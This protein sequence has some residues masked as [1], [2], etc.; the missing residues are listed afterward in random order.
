[1]DKKDS[2]QIDID[3]MSCAAC[4]LRIEKKL[5]GLEG[6]ESVNVNL[7]SEKAY[8][9]YDKSKLSADTIINAVESL[10]YHAETIDK[11]LPG[12]ADP[13]GKRHSD[14]LRNLFIISA[15]LSAPLVLGMILSV[16]GINI[17]I[18]HD[19]RFQI[20]LATPVQFII[21][22]RFYRNAF[23]AIKS[24]SANM[25][26]LVVLGTSAAYFFSVYN[27]VFSP[28]RG[29]EMPALYFEAS[30]LIITLILMGKYL[31]SAAK[32]RTSE[33]IRKLMGLQAKDA[34]VLRNGL[35]VS[36]PVEQVVPGDIVIVRPGEKIPVDGVIIEGY[37][38]VDESMVTGES[39]P[40]EKTV[41][42][43]VIGSTVNKFGSF[44]F[45]AMKVGEDTVL[46][47]I[48]K[49]VE[50][51]QGSK[52]PIQKT[53]DKVASVFVPAVAGIALL[54]FLGWYFLSSGDNRFETALINAVSVLVI[55]CPCALGLATPT[56]IMV[57]TGVGAENGILIKSGEILEISYKINAVILDKTGTITKGQPA[58][59]DI[60]PVGENSGRPNGTEIPESNNG[61]KNTET[62]ISRIL[63][64]AG[65]AERNSEHPLGQAIYEKALAEKVT[66][67]DTREFES[68]P[69]KGVKALIEGHMVIAGNYAL[70]K[71]NGIDAGYVSDNTGMLEDMGKTAILIAI[72][73]KISAVIGVADIIKDSSVSAVAKL[74]NMGIKVYMVT[75]DN[76]RTADAIGRQ[77]GIENV[78]AG[79][80]PEDKAGIAEKL[81]KEGKI[82]AVAGDGINDAPALASAHIGIAMGTGT[83]IA[84]EAGDITILRGDLTLIPQAIFLSQKTISKIRQNLFWAFIY[85]IIGI[86]FAAFG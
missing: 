27:A 59:T 60:V 13:T 50:K 51:A 80:L 48:V 79:V 3:G 47:Q 6:V 78:R 38:N 35:E 36:M 52:A 84:I 74:K 11:T 62:Q 85:N 32:G 86:P 25:D 53:A 75:G 77:A 73:G 69:G 19:W 4:A 29:T 33:A 43:H 30:A 41:D 16:F 20:A 57:G 17:R 34:K 46:S 39:I 64:F 2:L 31:E 63:K 18:L 71:D 54:T 15:F 21:G 23:Y 1:M 81:K 55:A 8:I 83:D 45:K 56:A 14:S 72:D 40:A 65:A 28:Q 26:V 10:G 49:M 66:L 42:D 70:M 5:S 44:K 37:S 68:I 67:P 61:G 82:V 7:A 22:A 12:T 9:K 76:K 58:V 24:G